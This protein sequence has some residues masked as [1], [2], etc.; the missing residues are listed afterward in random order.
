MAEILPLYV[1]GGKTKRSA[2]TDSQ[3]LGALGLGESVP[4]EG[5]ALT[6]GTASNVGA[7]F[8]AAS[9]QSAN[10]LEIKDSGGTVTA[11]FDSSGKLGL[12]GLA[13]GGATTNQVLTWNGSA[14][15]PADAA[16]GVGSLVVGDGSDGTDNAV[17]G[18]LARSVYQYQSATI[19]GDTTAPTGADGCLI[20]ATGTLTV[21]VSTKLSASARGTGGT[22]APGVTS[23]NGNPGNQPSSGNGVFATGTGGT[24]GAGG[25]SGN[26]SAGG[27]GGTT[28]GGGGGGGG[29]VSGGGTG[30]AGA[31]GADATI[32][33]KVAGATRLVPWDYL[34]TDASPAGT[35][36]SGA[37]SGARFSG[38]SGAGGDG[39]AGTSWLYVAVD[40]L[41]GSGTIE[42][43]GQNGVN[44]SD[45]VSGIAAGGGG[46]GGGAGG[47]LF[48]RANTLGGGV[49]LQ[50]NG[51]TGGTGGTGDGGNGKDGGSGG[52]GGAGVVDSIDLP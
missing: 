31:A 24:S 39:G 49:T 5:L 34:T 1:D 14:W 48:V 4:T 40:E 42:A 36:G 10:V 29:G 38:T 6:I 52:N 47:I 21:N 26:G 44:G 30:G 2:N 25:T 27:V 11:A 32:D 43:S 15:A 46:G 51:G 23:S 3:R 19:T 13:Q 20:Y 12:S 7:I 8:K 16:S 9:S 17:T 37:G 50:A 22:G 28:A 18:T 45:R 35:P 33:P 41:A